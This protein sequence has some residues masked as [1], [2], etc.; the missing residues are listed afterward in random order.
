[1]RLMWNFVFSTRESSDLICG[2]STLS[3]SDY[4]SVVG[5]IKRFPVRRVR[6]IGP[7]TAEA[8]RDKNKKVQAQARAND[9][10]S[11]KGSGLESDYQHNSTRI[12]FHKCEGNTNH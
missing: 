10:P 11:L 9:C 8:E 1:M 4:N 6:G 5:P 7:A 12:Q 2:L 3:V